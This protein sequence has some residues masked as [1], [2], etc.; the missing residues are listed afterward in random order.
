MLFMSFC[1]TLSTLCSH[2]VFH[3]I[4]IS[5]ADGK[6][7]EQKVHRKIAVAVLNIKPLYFL[8]RSFE[9]LEK[10]C[11]QSFILFYSSN[12]PL[13]RRRGGGFR[14]GGIKDGEIGKGQT[15]RE[16]VNKLLIVYAK[17]NKHERSQCHLQLL[18]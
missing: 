11:Q 16:G 10:Y 6:R 5:L 4:R 18:C 3:N 12:L 2:V 7:A 15:E 9:I 14:E 13:P 1:R 17:R 8:S